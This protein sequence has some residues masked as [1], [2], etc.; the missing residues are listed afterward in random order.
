MNEGDEKV[1]W[2]LFLLLRL[3]Q[4]LL[5][6]HAKSFNN[7][8]QTIPFDLAQE[9]QKGNQ[10]LYDMGEK[11]WVI[12]LAQFFTTVRLCVV[13]FALNFVAALRKERIECS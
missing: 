11:I 10:H 8:S 6:L 1:N 5:R 7:R 9:M 3:K 2:H 12:E 13:N 4:N